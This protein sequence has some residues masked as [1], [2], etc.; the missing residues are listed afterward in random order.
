MGFK[1]LYCIAL[2]AGI[3]LISYLCK[4]TAAAAA[5]GIILTAVPLITAKTYDI[6]NCNL[7]ENKL[8]IILS[9]DINNML[10][11]INY[12]NIAGQPIKLYTLYIGFVVLLTVLLYAVISAISTKRGAVNV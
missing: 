2:S 5:C 11:G 7:Q 4:K 3:M 1:S 12:V 10:S 6:F 8:K 9:C